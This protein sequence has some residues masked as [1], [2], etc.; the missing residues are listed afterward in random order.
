MVINEELRGVLLWMSELFSQ[1][2]YGCQ[3]CAL[4]H[5]L[6]IRQISGVSEKVKLVMVVLRVINTLLRR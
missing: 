4:V 3:I 5:R 1:R 6:Q 2:E